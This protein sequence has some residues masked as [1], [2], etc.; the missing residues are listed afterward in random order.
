[1]LVLDAL[2]EQ[3]HKGQPL[4]LPAASAQAE[5]W[6]NRSTGAESIVIS[7]AMASLESAELFLSREIDIN[8]INQ[9]FMTWLAEVEHGKMPDQE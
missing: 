4:D 1:M 7:P 8:E 5:V 6:M 9:R 3:H 2:L